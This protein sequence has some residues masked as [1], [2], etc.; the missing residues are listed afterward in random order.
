MS[1][2]F[3]IALLYLTASPEELRD[4]LTVITEFV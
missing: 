1:M 3:I 2:T 4:I